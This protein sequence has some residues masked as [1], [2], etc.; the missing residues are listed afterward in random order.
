MQNVKILCLQ[1]KVKP[2]NA[3]KE[4]GVGGSFINDIERGRRP[5]VTKGQMLADY[6]GVTTSELLG[7]VPMGTYTKEIVAMSPSDLTLSDAERALV[8]AYR[9]ATPAD[10]AIIDNIINRYAPADKAENLA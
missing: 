4:S 5:L 8:S 10:R 7:E 9:I 3:C 2:T 1:R 6:L